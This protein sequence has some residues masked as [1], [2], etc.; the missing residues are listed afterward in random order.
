[1]AKDPNDFTEATKIKVFK[2]AAYRCSFPG[3][4]ISLIGP[5]SDEASGGTV[6]TGEISH[7]SGARPAP[8]NRYNAHLEPGQRSHHSNAIALCRTHAKLI[9][10]DEDKYTI[11]LICGWKAEHEEKASR[12]QAG[13]NVDNEY[14][15]KPYD[16]CSNE[17]LAADR[18]YRNELIKKESARL[19]KIALKFF[20]GGGVGAAI[21]FFW[22]L[23]NGGMSLAMLAAGFVFCG[24][25]FMVAF[26]LMDKKND[27]IIKQ[28]AAIQDIN[29]RL[30]VRGAE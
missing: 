23:L 24:M 29:Y 10:S 12:R 15:E 9:D 26:N 20:A 2:R 13:E 19:A 6:L 7:I 3:C 28:E 21:I 16:K 25:P 22:Y 17:E 5:H 27:F 18:V 30:K 1:M 8:N 11:S 14:Y 4:A